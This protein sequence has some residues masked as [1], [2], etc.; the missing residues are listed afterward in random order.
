MKKKLLFISAI[1][2]ILIC[3]FVL[4]VTATTTFQTELGYVI[5]PYNKVISP[6][7][8]PQTGVISQDQTLSY[9]YALSPGSTELQIGVS[10][11]LFPFN[12]QL[13]MEIVSPNGNFLGSYT[14]SYDGLTDGNILVSIR[15]VSLEDGVWTINITGKSVIGQ[16]PFTLIIHEL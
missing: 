4:P 6:H 5:T 13:S 1:C 7:A 16:Q 12:N 11:I 2:A 15:S 9:T 10:W 8:L 14:D 3:Y